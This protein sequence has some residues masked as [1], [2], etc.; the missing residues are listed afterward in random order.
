MAQSLSNSEEVFLLKQLATG[1]HSSYKKLFYTFYKDLCRF[2]LKYVRNE[3]IAEE[4]VQDVFIYIWEKREVINIT[5]SLKSYL[6]TAVRNKSINYLKLQLPKEQ[7]NEDI[8]KYEIAGT[9]NV[10][11]DI[12]YAELTER[13][14]RA[15]NSLPKKCR[16]IFILSRE[17]GQTYKEIAENLGISAKTVENQMVIALRK[18]RKQLS[19]YWDNI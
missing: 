9:S 2:G 19:P 1:D 18:L 3:E 7:L 17:D 10:E 5:V 14:D 8:S 11:S 4:I 16:A 6:Y 13:I 15:I 12:T